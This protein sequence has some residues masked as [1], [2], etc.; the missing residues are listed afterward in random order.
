MS[1]NPELSDEHMD[2]PFDSSDPTSLKAFAEELKKLT[3]ELL[4]FHYWDHFRVADQW[5]GSGCT[6]E[7]CK[8]LHDEI[9][10]MSAEI[11][12]RFTA[13]HGRHR[14]VLRSPHEESGEFDWSA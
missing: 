6:E 4:V 12:N 7:A 8:R 11:V 5:V 10:V 3:D 14:V 2:Q 13:E 9:E 1:N